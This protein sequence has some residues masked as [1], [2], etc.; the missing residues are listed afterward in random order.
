MDRRFAYSAAGKKPPGKELLL[1]THG[2]DSKCSLSRVVLRLTRHAV[3]VV[4]LLAGLAPASEAA[5]RG[6]F[7]YPWYPQTWTVN[8]SHVAYHPLLG[9]YSSS[10][11]SVVDR[12][13]QWLNYANVGV[14]IASWF[15]PGSQ[16][17][18]TRIP[19]LLSRTVPPLEWTLYYE[20]EG[21]PTQGSSCPS[22]GPNPSVA[23]IQSDLNY[24]SA[25]AGSPSYARVNGKPLIF[26]WSAGDSACE[27]ADRWRQAAPNWYVVL[28]LSSGYK[29]CPNQPDSWHQYGPSSATH[30]HAG[31]SYV[32]SPGFKRADGAGS[33]LTRDINRWYQQVRDMVASGE[34]WQLVTT[35]NEWGEGT[36]V[37]AAEEWKSPSGAGL[38]LDALH[39]QGSGGPG[40]SV[41]PP[42]ANTTQP[43]RLRALSVAPR[44]FRAA[45]R[46]PGIAARIG[47]NVRY[48][49][50]TRAVVR[51]TVQR[52]LPGRRRGQRCARTRRRLSPRKR[53]TRYRALRGKLEHRGEAGRNRL[54]FRGRVGGR[55]LRRG[56]YRL[57]AVPL[58]LAGR[59][60]ASRS[61]RFRVV[62]LRG[63]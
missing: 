3:V 22:G 42:S 30:H 10:D 28:K 8:G 49:L 45:R 39:S 25:Y 35:F 20:C 13:V 47:T 17:E 60:G 5:T 27:V 58:D 2:R 12:H 44:A 18:S 16:S 50:S 33:V 21:N 7:Y 9:Y 11:R 53:C 52:A 34:P 38:Y 15:G 61:A 51:L 24:A 29:Q 36:A 55:A 4:A 62:R 54:H 41:G 6:A 48:T 1:R 59:V 23:A 46:G 31:Y 40:G 63:V 19:L 26:V 43:P 37:E 32:I 14:A 57:V 56:H